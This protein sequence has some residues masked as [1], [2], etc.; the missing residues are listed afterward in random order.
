MNQ[1]LSWGKAATVLLLGVHAAR[2]QSSFTLYNETN[3]DVTL[4]PE[5][6]GALTSS[7]RC[8]PFVRSFTELA[9]RGSLQNVA[10]TDD[11]CSSECLGSLTGWFNDVTARCQGKTVDGSVPNRLGGYLWA[12]FNE[13]CVRDPRTKHYCNDIIANFTVVPDYT[14]MRRAELC[15]T[16]HIRRLALMQASQYSIYDGY[17]QDLLEYVYAQCGGSG[18]TDIPPPLTVP[19]PEPAP[20][21]VSGKRY[22]TTRAGETCESIANATGVSSAALYLGNQALLP[23]CLDV[24]AGVSVC[25]PLACQTYYVRPDDTCVAIETALALDF[26][27][28]RAYNSWVNFDCSNLQPASD[29]WGRIICVSPQGGTFTGTA[30]LPGPTESPLHDG[31]TRT[32]VA[33]PADVPVAADTT[34]KCGK[35]HVVEAGDTC[36]TICVRAGIEAGL[37]RRVNPSLSADSCT[38]SLQPRT[39]LCVGPTYSW[40]ATAPSARS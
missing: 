7:I 37:F 13:T 9:Y 5:C 23:D 12:G 2:A 22:T 15:H 11:V 29:F 14:Q 8:N 38:A 1:L 30:P 10:L 24:D 36:S 35:W 19:S 16:C 20:Y 21:C 39:A 25:V 4:G 3:L 26:G 17:Y 40:D 6:I 34:L 18:A 31:Y 28:I 33:P 32:P 27:Q